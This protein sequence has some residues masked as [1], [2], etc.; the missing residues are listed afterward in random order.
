VPPPPPPA[1]PKKR[2]RPRGS[3]NQRTLALEALFAGESEA[4][5]RKAITLALAGD[6]ICL[7]MLIDRIAPAP[8]G[9]LVEVPGFPRI[10][11]L[12]DVPAAM[13][14]LAA[15]VARGDLTADEAS[16]MASIIEKFTNACSAVDQEQRLRALE[17]RY[18]STQ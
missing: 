5:A 4:I 16:D 6:P 8:R 7:R 10:Q 3:R 2:G 1:A 13:A 18:A 15:A 12:D 11:S 9:R 14:F 17:E